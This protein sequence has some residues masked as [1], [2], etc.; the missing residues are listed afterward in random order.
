M[1][2]LDNC[3]TCAGLIRLCCSL[4]FFPTDPEVRGLLIERLHRL[5]KDHHHAKDMIDRWLDTQTVAPKVANLVELAGTVR[6]AS[7]VLPAGCDVCQGEPWVVNDRGAA[8]CVC[9]RGQ[10]LRE[11]GRRNAQE[12]EQK[13]EP[14]ARW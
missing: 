14:A 9:A 2:R 8:R 6:A 7:Q 13:P 4:D 11:M 12:F 1:E 10:A 3:K 5:A